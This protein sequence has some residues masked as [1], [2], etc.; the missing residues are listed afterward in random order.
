LLKRAVAKGMYSKIT[1][2]LEDN[3]IYMEMEEEEEEEEE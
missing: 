1:E 3:G 2:Y